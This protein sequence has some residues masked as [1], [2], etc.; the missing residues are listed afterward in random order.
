M[1][2]ERQY[3]YIVFGRYTPEPSIQCVFNKKE[4]ADEYVAEQSEPDRYEV[5]RHAVY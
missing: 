3:V 2:T 5:N 1:K 4:D